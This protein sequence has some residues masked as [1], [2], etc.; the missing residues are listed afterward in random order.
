MFDPFFEDELQKI[1]FQQMIPIPISRS[2]FLPYTVGCTDQIGTE[3][4]R[5]GPNLNRRIVEFLWRDWMRKV[6]SIKPERERCY[7]HMMNERKRRKKQRDCYLALHSILP[8]GTKSDKSSIVQMAEKEI[9]GLKKRKEE[10]EA[11]MS[12]L[13]EE[14][15]GGNQEQREDEATAEIKVMV[16][17]PSLGIDSLLGVLKC[18]NS[19]GSA[20]RFIQSHISDYELSAVLQIDSKSQVAAAEIKNAV[21]RR[22]Y[23]LGTKNSFV[24]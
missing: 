11:R 15:M 6:E 21:Q 4:R 18:I 12:E 10:L 8:Q 19:M 9:M 7:K 17:N 14:L 2:A 16:D 13:Q 22:L 1:I 24:V 3:G 5:S 20:A 23:Q